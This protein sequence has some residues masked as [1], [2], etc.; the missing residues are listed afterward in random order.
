MKEW[1][2]LFYKDKDLEIS[3]SLNNSLAIK[4][5]SCKLLG[6]GSEKKIYK[7]PNSNQCFFVPSPKSGNDFEDWK[8]VIETEKD[9]LN[10]ISELGLR[11]QHFEIQPLTLTK[12][13]TNQQT[14]DVLVTRDF[15]S[16]CQEEKLI[17]CD[18]K[19][20]KGSRYFGVSEQWALDFIAMRDRFKDP[21]FARKML[22]QIICDYAIA[23][24]FDLPIKAKRSEYALLGPD[25]DEHY[26]FELAKNPEDP[27]VVRYMFWDVSSGPA[28]PKV[29]TLA[30]LKS[31]VLSGALHSKEETYRAL[32]LITHSIAADLTLMVELATGRKLGKDIGSIDYTMELRNE[33]FNAINDDEFLTEALSEAKLQTRKWLDKNKDASPIER[34][35]ESQIEAAI[36]L[37]DL[38][39]VEKY[40]ES[41]T[42]KNIFSEK[43]IHG[44]ID[45]A[46]EYDCPQIEA[47]FTDKLPQSEIAST[48]SEVSS[49]SQLEQ[50]PPNFSETSGLGLEQSPHELRHQDPEKY[51]IDKFIR[52]YKDK[53]TEDK[54]SWCGFF[55]T[56]SYA[57]EHTGSL[58]ELVDHAK[59]KSKTGSGARTL[60]IMKNKLGWLDANNEPIG[61]LKQFFDNNCRSLNA[62]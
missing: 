19:H 18:P 22:K 31:G 27:P 41:H 43:E 57:L 46:Q 38:T 39:L 30:Q 36:S 58:Q 3:L 7:I 26:C 11:T 17:I 45:M 42:E 50:N 47:F 4:K 21:I 37:G 48:R 20:H 29:P 25:D 61:E 28:N 60:E 24:T 16:L 23:L 8:D 6:E 52:A 59:G 44:F 62:H 2:H 55:P 33:L 35:I 5:D 14:I 9:R 1:R 10:A 54:S 12:T 34:Q 51:L 40:Y 32:K 56:R 49:L 15:D 53:L 13:A